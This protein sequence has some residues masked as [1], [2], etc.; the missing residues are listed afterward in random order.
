MW[1]ELIGRKI[2]AHKY[3]SL[4]DVDEDMQRIFENCAQYNGESEPITQVQQQLQR[5]APLFL[6]RAC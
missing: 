5:S 1:M 4:D 6:I 2:K 3:K